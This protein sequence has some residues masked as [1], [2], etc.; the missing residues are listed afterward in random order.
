MGLPAFAADE[1]EHSWSAEEIVVTATRQAEPLSKVA[2]SVAAFSQSQMDAQGVRD[3]NDITRLTPSLSLVPVPG[4]DI[5]GN[6]RSI[7]IRGISSTVGS[8]TTGIYLDDTPIQVRSLGNATSNTYPEIFDLERVEVLRGPQGTLFGA[9]AEGGA[10]RFI[11]PR[12][13]LDR[14]SVYGRSEL[15]FTQKGDP[16]YEA[17]AAV[18]VPI[19]EGELGIRASA[20]YRQDGG[21]VDRVNQE[22]LTVADANSNSQSTYALRAAGT[23]KASDEMTAT[24]SI[25]HQ[26]QDIDDSSVLFE[27]LSNLKK[28]VFRSARPLQQPVED[29]FTLPSLTVEWELDGAEVISTTSFFHRDSSILADYTNFTGAVVQGDPYFFAPGEYTLARLDDSQRDFTQELRVQS[30]DE[31]PLQWVFGV[32]YGRSKQDTF[33]QNE[34]IFLNVARERIGLPAIPLLNGIG[35]FQ[36]TAEAVDKQLAGFGQIDYTVFDDI[37]LTAGVRVADTNLKL[38]R[39]SRGPIVGPEPLIFSEKQSETPVTPKFGISWE[40]DDDNFFYATVAKGY[41]IGGVNGPQL[42]LCAES[43]EQLG[44]SGTPETYDSDSVWSYEA[45]AKNSLGPVRLNASVFRIDW[46]DIQREIRLP[47][48]GSGFVTN[49]GSAKSEGFDLQLDVRA[50]DALTFGG[51]I[52]YANARLT[53]DV[54]G[55]PSD[56]GGEPPVFGAKGD[57]LGVPAWN[58]TAYFLYDF[59]VGSTGN[60]Y[61]RGD[62]QYTGNGPQPSQKVTGADPLIPGSEEFHQVSLRLGLTQDR[63]DWSV[64]VDN[65]LNEA[66]L[67]SRSHD[68]LS[69][70]LFFNQTVRPRTVGVT[71]VYRY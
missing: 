47:A 6:R 52:G 8:A 33:Q 17:G 43:L 12:P 23:W 21:W 29:K 9:G 60:G 1:D 62:Y 10:V 7:A 56:P 68:T 38:A 11:T 70:P 46:N 3:I 48:C 58:F 64:F 61:L 31:S 34:D 39:D 22:T 63:W 24:L 40:A 16:S 36:T 2:I 32:F 59:A 45:G 14:M 65:L 26:N 44:I 28:G 19:V 20:W 71:A 54:V 13:N 55:L 15:A 67:L 41:R 27:N 42:N 50:S 5:A 66:P 53:E 18:G 49:L 51:S 30:L 37:T 57:K 25:F 4:P 35:V 69:S